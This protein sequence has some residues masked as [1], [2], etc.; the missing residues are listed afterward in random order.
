MEHKDWNIKLAWA[1]CPYRFEDSLTKKGTMWC[2]CQEG[3][4]PCVKENCPIKIVQEN[5]NINVDDN[6]GSGED[7]YAGDGK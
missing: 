1:E 2:R 3:N 5:P 7:E 6:Y 4:P